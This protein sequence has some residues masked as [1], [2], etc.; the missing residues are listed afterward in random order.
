MPPKNQRIVEIL[1]ETYENHKKRRDWATPTSG[2]TVSH[3][4]RQCLNDIVIQRHHDTSIDASYNNIHKHL[5]A[6]PTSSVTAVLL[7]ASGTP[8]VA[9]R[10]RRRRRCR[11]GTSACVADCQEEA[12][13][14]F[15]CPTPNKQKQRSLLFIRRRERLG[16]IMSDKQ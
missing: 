16:R 13:A 14:I 6:A 7:E 5:M 12:I 9:S 11:E 2:A 8:S 15:V 1:F 3:T 10:C 4:G